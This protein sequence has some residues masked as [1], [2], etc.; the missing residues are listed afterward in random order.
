MLHSRAL[1]DYGHIIHYLAV[2]ELRNPLSY[3]LWIRISYAGN[4]LRVAWRWTE[5]KRL[6]SAW[7]QTQQ[8]QSTW[9][10]MILESTMTIQEIK[11][12]HIC[13]LIV[14]H[15]YFCHHTYKSKLWEKI[16]KWMISI[17]WPLP[18]LLKILRL[19]DVIN[20]EAYQRMWSSHN[21]WQFF[22]NKITD[23]IINHF[24]QRLF[25]IFIDICPNQKKYSIT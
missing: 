17:L 18:H 22:E 25:E 5:P 14:A 13:Q 23:L 15:Y 10:S 2:E 7:Y 8:W 4:L 6:R 20:D 19:S 9:L 16:R 21:W 1:L 3:S 11:T 12:R 24:F